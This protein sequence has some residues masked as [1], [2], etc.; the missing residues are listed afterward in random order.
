MS[1]GSESSYK[2]S[3]IQH[4]NP[5]RNQQGNHQFSIHF[6]LHIKLPRAIKTCSI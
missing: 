2:F 3:H 6:Q 5:A 4:T 1:Y